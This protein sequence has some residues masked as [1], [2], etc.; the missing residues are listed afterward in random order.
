VSYRGLVLPP[1]AAAFV[2]EGGRDLPLSLVGV[3]EGLEPARPLRLLTQG[4]EVLGL[5]FADPENERIRLLALASEGFDTL[6]PAFFAARVGQALA[7]RRTL[8]LTGEQAAYRLLHGAADGLPGFSADVL[9]GWAVVYVHGRA[10]L[11]HGRLLAQAAIEA[12][13]LHGAVVKLRS[14]GAA[15]QGRV[16]QEIVGEAPPERLVV[17]ERGVP[18][19][20]HLDRGLNTGLFTDMREHR[21]AL[22]RLA[23]GKAILN[24]FSYTSTLS[25][26]A[27]RAGA[28]SVTSVDLSSGVL[29]WARDNFRLSGL[30]P[31]APAF[32][33][34]AADVGRFL[35]EEARGGR[36]FDLVL[37]DPPAFSAARGAAF[38]LDRDFPELVAR[39]CALLTD[40]GLLWLA[41]NARGSSLV[42]LAQ[43]GFRRAH[44][45]AV[46]LEMGGL[47]ADHP[48]VAVQPED[49][50]LQVGLFRPK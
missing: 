14:R 20:V 2:A 39:A 10:F 28:A 46:L 9:G 17:E 1:A 40:G 18:F 35:E 25:V 19:E 34:E 45:E 48:T 23:A 22:A 31:D 30:D 12:G 50:Y 11:P 7:L 4:G 47:P 8:G 37:L 27:A 6:G 15:S 36:R 42:A 3:A 24:G 43:E 49:R 32:R 44:R 5:A 21:H 13:G 16:R 29:A 41:C 38:A 33:F 26:V